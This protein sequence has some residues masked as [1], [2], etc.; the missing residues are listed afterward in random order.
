M[1]TAIPED[2]RN[3]IESCGRHQEKMI[4]ILWRCPQ[5]PSNKTHSEN[6]DLHR[7]TKNYTFDPSG[8]KTPY[9]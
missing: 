2:K 9:Q 5:I 6:C 3:I 7:I 8:M 1:Q 4:D